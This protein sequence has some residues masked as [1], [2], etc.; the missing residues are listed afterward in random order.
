MDAIYL[1]IV[2]FILILAVFDL[3]VGVSNDAVNFL[4]SA[5]GAK[6][7]KFK[8]IIAIAAI[9]ILVGAL[10]SNGM[11]DIARHGMFHPQHFYF[12]EIMCIFLA[13]MVTDVFLLD[14]FNTLGMP[15]S[16]TVSMVFELLGGAFAM[17]VIKYVSTDGAVGFGQMLNTEKAL[18]VIAG[19]FLSVAIAFVFGTLVQ[20]I[21]RIIFTFNFK[22][23]LRWTIGIFGGIAITSIVY[24]MLVKGLKTS[25]I[26]TPEL[27]AWID[28]NTLKLLLYMFLGF[29]VIMQLLHIC[30][31]NVLRVVVLAGTFALAMAFAGNDLV[32][33]IGVPLAGL[34]S[35]HYYMGEGSGV[36]GEYLMGRLNEPATSPFIYLALAGVVMVIAL[37]TSKKAH[38][39][40]KTSLDLS[41][42]SDSDEIFGSSR[43]ARSLVRT[44]TATANT[45]SK[46]IPKGISNWV[47]KRFDNS[48][49]DMPEGAAFDMVRAAVNLVLAGLLI[50]AGT[51][52]KL[53][54]STTYV[55]FMVAMGSSLADRAWGRESAVFR[56][57]GVISVIGGWFITAGAA[58]I[59]AFL[60]T[61]LMHF[62]GF[63]VM[64]LLIILTIYLLIRSNIRYKKREAMANSEDPIFQDM[65]KSKNPEEVWPLLQQHFAQNTR[66]EIG[67]VIN[68]Y[69]SITDAFINEEL[70]PLRKAKNDMDNELLNTKRARKREMVCLKKVDS[71][72]AFKNNTWLHLGFNSCEQMIYCLKR[73]NEPCKEHVD[74]NFTPLPDKYIKDFL[75]VRDKLI[76]YFMR[77]NQ[78]IITK[79]YPNNIGILL[80]DCENLKDELSKLR[81]RLIDNMQ[82]QTGSTRVYMVYLNMLQ[83]SQEVV[84]AYRHLMRSV[85]N[86]EGYPTTALTQD[87]LREEIVMA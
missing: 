22:K 40:V 85:S 28:S 33:F 10:T 25:T 15:T 3:I 86:F 77:G 83:E 66:Q 19:I 41:K 23:H 43:I 65:V 12:T 29:T 53:P 54:L 87:D 69:T 67:F 32:N 18:S 63:I 76:A 6:A 84:S 47:N 80:E 7:A 73:I 9:G 21:A 17:A 37:L 11:M 56:I 13:V 4:N 5:I 64:G 75:P 70:K 31:V 61:N 36:P 27:K 79:D 2:A 16:T 55:T 26:M 44:T 50:A 60:V 51:S 45:I 58:F 20:W 1:V 62:G 82:H 78:M 72:V 81:K 68:T 8:T 57:T 49:S 42:Q 71:K 74:N 30:K 48:K 35:Y 52:L 46:Y 34:D 38:N 39:V 14:M 59:L 24:F